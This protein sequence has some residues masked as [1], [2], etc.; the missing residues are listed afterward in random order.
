MVTFMFTDGEK[1]QLS[2]VL[3]MPADAAKRSSAVYVSPSGHYEAF[4]KLIKD[5]KDAEK[6][7][8]SSL[9]VLRLME[10]SAFITG[11]HKGK[12]RK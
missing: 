3:D 1:D 10:V 5:V 6:I 7:R 8:D 12:T 4:T 11:K 2:E 9:A